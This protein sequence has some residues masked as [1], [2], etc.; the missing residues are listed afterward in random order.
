MKRFA[1]TGVQLAV[2]GV[3]AAMTLSACGSSSPT[4][5][6]VTGAFGSIPTEHGT[7]TGTGTLNLPEFAG[8]PPTDIFP[9]TPSA[10]NSIGTV[11]L[12][13]DFMWRPLYWSPDGNAQVIDYPLSTGE[14]PVISNGGKTFTI[15]LNPA[16]K[17]SN[18]AAVTAD[19]VLFDYDLIKAAIAENPA[20][21][22]GYVPG[23][24]PANATFKVLGPEQFSLTFNKTYNE[25]WLFWDEVGQ[26]IPLPS[27]A[28]NLSSATKH[29]SM[30]SWETLKGAESVFNYL[31]AQSALKS[32]YATNPVWKT[33]DGPFTLTAFNSTTGSFSMVPNKSYGGPSYDQARFSTLN[34]IFYTDETAEYDAAL[35]GALSIAYLPFQNL[36]QLKSLKAKGFEV[37]GYPGMG[38]N[39]IAYNF[40]DTTDNWNNVIAQLY[41]RQALA[42]L[43]N[44]SAEI[45]GIFL[46]AAIPAYTTIPSLPKTAY[47]PTDATTDPYPYSPSTTVSI[48]KSHGW[49]VVPGGQTTCAKAGSGAG[50]CGAGIPA[51]T[52][53]SFNLP[54]STTPS[55]IGELIDSL[56][57]TAKSYAGITITPQAKT[58]T[59]ITE[60]DNDPVPS[61]AKYINTWNA[62]QF[63]GYTG[64]GYPTSNQI[65]N[66]GGGG[67]FGDFSNPAVDAAI[68]GSLN[69]PSPTAL[70]N[71]G[72]VVA[73]QLPGIFE[74]LND[75]II[76]WK[77]NI[78]GPAQAF[79]I[80]TQY[81]YTPEQFYFAK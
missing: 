40:K 23:Q 51:G 35:S 7:P 46:G 68:N 19:D 17:W 37:Y 81:E 29:V 14:K 44:E 69:S 50:E 9:V 21:Y 52:A 65:F 13:E 73:E 78:S 76:M 32:T 75:N 4:K 36:P 66:T 38:F 49:K 59:F 64:N 6:V 20:N 39:Y 79:E 10:Y 70:D 8:V 55:W 53:L 11:T 71:E 63:G 16:Y 28:W 25:G 47:I 24:F 2:V 61:D 26:L 5:A 12:F 54:Y 30:S 33:V 67:N 57:S 80:F 1:R 22:A 45:K 15:T 48:L 31:T 62:T 58:F 77:N 43:Q 18:G 41:V 3:A 27:T 60:N 42:H 72:N 56:A 74:P 34:M